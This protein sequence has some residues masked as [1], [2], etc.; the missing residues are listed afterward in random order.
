MPEWLSIPQLVNAI[1]LGMVAEAGWL[2]WR[3]RRRNQKG[4]PPLLLHVLSGA[5]L[6]LAMKLALH[7]SSP[8]IVAIVLG[9]A[10]LAHTCDLY[11]TLK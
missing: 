4:L 3:H 11:R 9:T 5:L 6:L 7:G 8:T 2:F 10:G 1:L